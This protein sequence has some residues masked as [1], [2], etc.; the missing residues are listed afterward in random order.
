MNKTTVTNE[1][2]LKG[3]GPNLKTNYGSA[4]Y[5]NLDNYNEA[6]IRSLFNNTTQEISD[7]EKEDLLNHVIS[8]YNFRYNMLLLREAFRVLCKNWSVPFNSFYKALNVKDDTLTTLITTG[9]CSDKN[10]K[11][12]YTA[13]KPTV[14]SNKYYRDNKVK[15]LT[16]SADIDDKIC[17]YLDLCC[18]PPSEKEGKE[19]W[20]KKEVL[21]KDID[22]NIL[23]ALLSKNKNVL[24]LILTCRQLADTASPSAETE[25]RKASELINI[26]NRIDFSEKNMNSKAFED[27][28]ID[29]AKTINNIEGDFPEFY[30][31]AQQLKQEKDSQ[32]IMN[33]I[34]NKCNELLSK[35][36]SK[37]DAYSPSCLNMMNSIADTMNTIVDI[38]KSIQKP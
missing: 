6:M 35:D 5:K 11:K 37:A 32:S 8:R 21:I 1:T 20:A 2:E 28:I 30:A 31:V 25:L 4:I 36:I 10:Y 24:I 33:E 23:S 38:M 29:L 15:Y 17:D 7:A 14:L 3:R 19:L 13:L 9:F 22:A 26:I 27:F 34:T 16:I 12:I 18:N